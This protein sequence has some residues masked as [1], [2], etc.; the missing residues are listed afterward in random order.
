MIMKELHLSILNLKSKFEFSLG[1]FLATNCDD[2]SKRVV[3]FL[4]VLKLFESEL[5]GD[6]YY[7]INLRTSVNIRKLINLPRDEE[8][9]IILDECKSIMSDSSLFHL[10]KEEVPVCLTIKQWEEAVNGDWVD[11]VG[12]S[13]MRWW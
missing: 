2:R 11:K 9:R 10:P 13:Q 1:H 7:D 6:A 12:E 5:F 8:V 4:Q 3:N